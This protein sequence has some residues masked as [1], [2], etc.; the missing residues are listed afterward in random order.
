MYDFGARFQDP[1]IGRWHVTEHWLRNSLILLH[2]FMP[3]IT[4]IYFIDP[5][6]NEITVYYNDWDDEKTIRLQSLDDIGVSL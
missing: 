4:P 3:L 2:M 6:G 1:Q 5:D